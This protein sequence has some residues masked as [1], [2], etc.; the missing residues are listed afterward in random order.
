MSETETELPSETEYTL[1]TCPTFEEFLELQ[2]PSPEEFL[3]NTV[4][5]ERCRYLRQ[6][7]RRKSWVKSAQIRVRKGKEKRCKK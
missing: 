1:Y 7:W 6:K 3:R 4:E 5:I 2:K